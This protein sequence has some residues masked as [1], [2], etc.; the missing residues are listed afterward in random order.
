MSSTQLKLSNTRKALLL[1]VIFS[2]TFISCKKE[3]EL[4]PEFNDEN[5]T[6]HFTDT[7]TIT[8]S[9]VKDDSIRTDISGANLLGIYNDSLMG[10]ASSS[11]FTEITLAGTNVS[12]GNNAVLDSAILSLKYL[13]AASFY[14]NINT[15][16]SI[17]VF[18]LTE[19]LNKNEYY[20]NEDLSA[21]LTPLGSKTFIPL[22]NDSTKIIINGDTV[23]LA[24]QVRIR[25]DDAFG[26][27]IIDLGKNSNSITN[28]Q[29]LKNL[30]NGFHITPT[31]TVNNSTLLKGEGAIITFDMN[32]SISTLTLYYH[33]D[34]E[35]NKSYSFLINSESKKY[36]RFKHNYANTDVENHLAGSGFD[37]TITYVQAMGGVKTKLIIPNI[38]KLVNEGNI[39]INKAELV[40]TIKEGSDITLNAIENM[41]LAGINSSGSPTFLIDYFEGAN[42]FG[43]T[44]DNNTKTYRFNISRH[45]QDLIQNNKEDY[46]L[47]LLP[48]GSAV[49]ANRSIINSFKHPSNKIKLNITYSKY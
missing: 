39:I 11:I 48:S 37:T 47:Y 22:T 8:T 46:G 38:K 15:P 18:Q 7:F 5:L 4:F 34:T 32:S 26:Q 14:G 43:G 27:S 23:K 12:F 6:I 21:N 42:Y 2:I 40:F 30:V 3:G 1:S 36:N 45:L 49:N 25:L 16:M 19:Q 44:L 10:L 20:S 9:V 28:N 24:P 17:N 13:N 31:S 41:V 29:I 33:N 35:S